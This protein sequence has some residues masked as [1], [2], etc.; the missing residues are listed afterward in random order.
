[1]L[2]VFVDIN[3]VRKEYTLQTYLPLKYVPSYSLLFVNDVL[4]AGLNNFD[5][6]LCPCQLYLWSQ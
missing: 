5:V 6:D 2:K 1:M 4:L 3:N